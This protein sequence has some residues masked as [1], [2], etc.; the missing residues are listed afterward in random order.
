MATKKNLSNLSFFSFFIILVPNILSIPV[1]YLHPSNFEL[2]T[3]SSCTACFFFSDLHQLLLQS[4]SLY[5]ISSASQIFPFLV[6]YQDYKLCKVLFLSFS[7]LKAFF[8]I[9]FFNFDAF[10][11]GYF[12]FLELSLFLNH[13]SAH[14]V[15]SLH[16]C[17]GELELCCSGVSVTISVLIFSLFLE[18]PLIFISY[19][20]SDHVLKA[21]I[22]HRKLWLL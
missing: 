9:C 17:S 21:M 7:L 1:L 18:K 2:I 19:R 15:F 20:V 11:F 12:R 8:R 13:L 10:I 14:L 6:L 5:I 3:D 16:F 4:T 22:W